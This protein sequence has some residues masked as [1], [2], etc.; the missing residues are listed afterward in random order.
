MVPDSWR[1]TIDSSSMF[2]MKSMIDDLIGALEPSERDFYLIIWMDHFLK[3][4][5]NFSLGT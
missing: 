1:W 3:I 5:Y 4:N 2:T